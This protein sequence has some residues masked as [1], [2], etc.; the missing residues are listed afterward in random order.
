MLNLEPHFLEELWSMNFASG[1][2]LPTFFVCAK[3]SSRLRSPIR[4]RSK[5]Q[6]TFFF[7]FYWQGWRTTFR[8]IIW[9]ES[10]TSAHHTTQVIT[11]HALSLTRYIPI[12]S[13]WPHSY[14]ISFL[15]F[16]C[17]SFFSWSYCHDWLQKGKVYPTFSVLLSSN[18]FN[19]DYIDCFHM[20]PS[21]SRFRNA[22]WR[23]RLCQ[24]SWTSHYRYQK[25]RHRAGTKKRI[26]WG[27]YS[28]TII[29]NRLFRWWVLCNRIKF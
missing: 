18:D 8:S 12:Q 1:W 15:S 21:T 27:M 25:G 9:T 20:S 17:L 29:S 13:L 19:Q 24:E 2:S 26:Q 11:L 14:H 3:D 7:F 5:Y 6:P 23:V 4:S 10:S 22:L 28:I 16:S